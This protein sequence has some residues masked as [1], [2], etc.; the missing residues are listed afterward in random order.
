VANFGYSQ[1]SGIAIN[2]K[3]DKY[4]LFPYNQIIKITS[5]GI[6]SVISINS[7]KKITN[8]LKPQNSIVYDLTSI[9]VDEQGTCYIAEV[10]KNQIIKIGLQ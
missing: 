1:I 4:I 3:N 2:K 9:T 5:D 10:D 7:S 6:K 8:G